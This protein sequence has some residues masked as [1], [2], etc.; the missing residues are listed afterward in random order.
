MAKRAK[1]TP[2]KT[3]EVETCKHKEGPVGRISQRVR[4]EVAGPMTSS[5]VIRHLSAR[6][7]QNTLR[8][9]ALRTTASAPLQ[10]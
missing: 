6:V 3:A 4:P 10:R 5:G 7:W 8:Y 1:P 9:S 2:G